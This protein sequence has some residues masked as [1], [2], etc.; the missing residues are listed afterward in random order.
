MT[1]RLAT[2][3]DIIPLLNLG[4]L[5][6]AESPRFQTRGWHRPKVTGL[7]DW[8]ISNKDGLLLVAEKGGQVIGGALAMIHEDYFSLDRSACELAIFVHPDH[9]GSLSGVR[10]VRGY[11]QW[12][13]D[14]GIPPERISAGIT[15]G[16]NLE[17][18]TRLYELAGFQRIGN[19]FEFKGK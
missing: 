6:H 3:A 13:Q 5:M 18:S 9:R 4:Q 10:L 14:N 2:P 19:L 17:Q 16:V 1:I 12:A 15:T 7:M 8:L 11:A